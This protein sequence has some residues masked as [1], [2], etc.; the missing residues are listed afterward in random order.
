MGTEVNALVPT[1]SRPEAPALEK[2]L[3][4]LEALAATPAGLTQAELAR[5]VGRSVGEIFRMLGTLERRGYVTRDGRSG[6]Y[7]LSLRLFQLAAQHPPARRM[8]QAA[9][10]VMEALAAELGQ[11]CHLGMVHGEHFI[12]VAQAEAGTPMG[13]VVRLGAVFPCSMH[14][15]S[16]RVLAAFQGERRRGELA[17][18][19]ARHDGS[20]IDEVLARLDHIATAGYD[21]APSEIV[22]GLTDISCPVLD[23]GGQA[24]AALTVPFF[25]GRGRPADLSVPLTGLREAAAT[26]S[27]KLGGPSELDENPDGRV[28]EQ[29]QRR[30]SRSRSQ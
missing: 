22:V 6:E 9:L 24:I 8:Q 30:Q 25:S 17:A 7:S 5:Q 14:Y 28:P 16:A 10:P 1:A 13:W 27:R 2:G 20:A 26:I 18:L 19:L 11:S 12:I 29:E 4:L 15:V 21:M 3:D 23:H